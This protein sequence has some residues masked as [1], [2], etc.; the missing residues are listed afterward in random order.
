MLKEG[1]VI[2]N[3][4]YNRIVIPKGITVF[5]DQER[6]EESADEFVPIITFKGLP[7][8]I[9]RDPLTGQWLAEVYGKTMLINF[10]HNDPPYPIRY[11]R[12]YFP[13]LQN[14]QN[15]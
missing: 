8:T 3:D 1:F 7:I 15:Q 9:W 2:R 4:V 5:L 14:P 12:Q 11:F 13:A 6:V 10:D